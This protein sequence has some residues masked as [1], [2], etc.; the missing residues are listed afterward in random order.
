[1]AEAARRGFD[2][3]SALRN[4]AQAAARG[5]PEASGRFHLERAVLLAFAEPADPAGAKE[6]LALARAA[7]L[8]APRG[9]EEILAPQV[10]PA[11]GR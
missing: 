10:A 5:A 9:L 7:G 6:A 1:M 8:A 2:R 3:A 11:P 4:E